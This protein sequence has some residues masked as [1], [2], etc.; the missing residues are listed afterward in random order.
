MMHKLI[1][2]CQIQGKVGLLSAGL[3]HNLTVE[4]GKNEK[5][6]AIIEGND[7]RPF[8]VLSVA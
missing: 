2:F 6:Q 3:Y 5:A 7:T 1:N 4:S 8:L